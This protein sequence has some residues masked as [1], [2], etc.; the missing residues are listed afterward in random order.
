GHVA[1]KFAKALGHHV[2]VIS[3]SPSKEAEAKQRLG[4]H[5]FI[6]SSNLQQMQAGRRSLDLILD[7]V[8]AQHSLLPVLELL[9]VNGTLFIVGAP[10]KPFELP[11]FPLIFG[12]RSVKGGIIGGM[13][14]TQEML[15]FCGKHNIACGIELTTPDKINEAMERL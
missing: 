2:T 5:D 3:T 8:S 10:D 9:K 7:T 1:V 12:K 4:A 13:K 15:D 11:A 6:V 14:E